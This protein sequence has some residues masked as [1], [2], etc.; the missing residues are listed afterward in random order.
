MEVAA[1]LGA[2]LKKASAAVSC[3]LGSAVYTRTLGQRLPLTNTQ[4]ISA[5]ASTTD[6]VSDI[7]MAAQVTIWATARYALSAGEQQT[8]QQLLLNFG[9]DARPNRHDQLFVVEGVAISFLILCVLL[10]VW[11]SCRKLY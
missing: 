6:W 10:L 5:F 9:T 7:V 1:T 2:S 4:L 8:C 3:D 11:R